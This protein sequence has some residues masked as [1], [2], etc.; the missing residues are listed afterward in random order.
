MSNIGDNKKYFLFLSLVAAFFVVSTAPVSSE[1]ISSENYSIESGRIGTGEISIPFTES[2][3]YLMQST[4]TGEETS[5]TQTEAKKI[6]VRLK[7]EVNVEAGF[8][9]EVDQKIDDIEVLGD[10]GK[11]YITYDLDDLGRQKREKVIEIQVEDLDFPSGVDVASHDD[12]DVVAKVYITEERS[13][14]ATFFNDLF[15]GEEDDEGGDG[16]DNLPEQLFDISLELDD[17]IVSSVKKLAAR[18]IFV[19]FG[20]EPTP[21]DLAFFILDEEENEVYQWEGSGVDI[22]VETEAVF[23]K[24]F[25]DAPD[26]PL[27]KY[28]L[29]AT[30]LYNVDVK[31][32]FKAEF[33]IKPESRLKSILESWWFWTIV[34]LA[35][36]AIFFLWFKKKNKAGKEREIGTVGPLGEDDEFKNQQ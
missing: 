12:E 10:Y 2:E 13:A 11:D 25:E 15:G 21:V 26:L 22:V 9:A 1:T 19:S 24:T 16:E 30:T 36:G 31:D 5:E 3:S 4:P 32:E 29:V 35:L 14:I 8:V 33:E 27:G 18:V 20:T 6:E 17:P 34:A 23:N 7:D 28:T